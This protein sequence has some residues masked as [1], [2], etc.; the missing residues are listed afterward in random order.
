MKA[1]NYNER[2]R[3]RNLKILE[4]K[5]KMGSKDYFVEG[6]R[7]PHCNEQNGMVMR[8][9]RTFTPEKHFTKCW[10]PKGNED[11]G[12]GCMKEFM[13]ELRIGIYTGP[14]PQQIEEIKQKDNEA[15]A[16]VPVAAE[17]QPETGP[18]L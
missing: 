14:T 1:K 13:V 7:C 4:E 12:S 18:S 15:I 5:Q 10:N 2:Q 8:P 9:M 3:L 16:P 11:Q 17:P 6:F